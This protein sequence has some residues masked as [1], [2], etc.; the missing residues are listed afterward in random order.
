MNNKPKYEVG[1]IVYYHL[2]K[3]DTYTSKATILDVINTR[4]D[5][6][7]GYMYKMNSSG[8]M[9]FKEK[10]IFLDNFGQLWKK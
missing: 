8:S 6:E 4:V 5:G 7:W 3:G 2:V 1:D 10:D 9:W